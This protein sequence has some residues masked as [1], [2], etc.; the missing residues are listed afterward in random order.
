MYTAKLAAIIVVQDSAGEG[1][2]KNMNDVRDN[3][4]A[5][6]MFKGDPLKKRMETAHPYLKVN[7]DYSM[8]NMTQLA[9][10]KLLADNQA[11][12][13][14]LPANVARNVVLQKQNCDVTVTSS[15]FTAGGGFM[16]SVESA[17][18]SSST[19]C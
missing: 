1:L 3:G 5:V 2:I 18:T 17:C 8:G 6:I 4:G 14:I 15:V 19:G 10:G 16:T 11:L 12:A 9:L 13:E 7:E